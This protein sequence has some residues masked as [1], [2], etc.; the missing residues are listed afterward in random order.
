M[1]KYSKVP[2]PS[3]IRRPFVLTVGL[4]EGYSDEGTLHTLEEAIKIALSWMKKR[5]SS[6]KAFLTGAF[7]QAEVVYAWPEGTGQ[8]GGG[9]EPVAEFHGEVSPL[10][11]ADLADEE[12]KAMLDELA[13][14]LGRVLGQTRI[15]V[16]YRDEAWVLQAEETATPTGETV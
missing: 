7:A 10:Y 4:Q 13:V 8:A 14:T 2:A 11:A 12:A 9:H 15:Y 16:A 3:D 5:A 6:G 1:K